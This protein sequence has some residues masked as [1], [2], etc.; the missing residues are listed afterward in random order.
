MSLS[1]FAWTDAD[2]DADRE[3]IVEDNETSISGNIS[4]TVGK[5]K[6]LSGFILYGTRDEDASDPWYFAG[7]VRWSSSNADIVSVNEKGVATAH[8]AGTVRITATGWDNLSRKHVQT[9]I[10]GVSS[11][12]KTT[13]QTSFEIG[14]GT[15]LQLRQLA[16]IN[17]GS[18]DLTWSSSNTTIASVDSEGLVLAHSVGRCI[19][20]AAYTDE[21]G[22]V[23]SVKYAIRVTTILLSEKT[24][25]STIL[26]M[27]GDSLDV[28]ILFYPNYQNLAS[29]LRQLSCSVSDTGIVSSSGLV[30]AANKA[31]TT[32]ASLRQDDDK[33]DKILHKIKIVVQ[34]TNTP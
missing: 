14:E 13:S 20:T 7:T 15:W 1:A 22:A 30:L 4:M 32:T 24:Q 16:E 2:T 8:K 25:E 18:A 6:D 5:S 34:G 9:I 23:H 12:P 11:A 10:V 27:L 29:A 31:G 17:T 28:G 26:L 3:L 33:D 19:I 21:T